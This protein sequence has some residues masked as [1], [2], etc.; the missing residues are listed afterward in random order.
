MILATIVVPA[1]DAEGLIGGCLAALERQ[2]VPRDRYEVVV[3]DDGSADG[4]A[5][6]ARSF[7]GVR[8]LRQTGRGPAAARTRGARAARGEIVVFTD[9]DCEPTEG[10]LAALLAPFA[11]PEVVGTKG[12]Y[13]T[14]QRALT[15]RFTQLEYEDKY[16]RMRRFERIDFID[17]YAAAFRRQV[18]LEAGGYDESFPVPSAEDVDLSYRMAAAGHLL[19]FAPAAAV[20]HR[21]PERPGVYLRRKYRYARWR[22]KAVART[23]SKAVSDSHSPLANK[24]QVVLMVPLAALLALRAAGAPARRP[25]VGAVAAHAALSLPFVVK[26]ARRDPSVAA[27][28]PLMLLAR[29]AFQ[30]A[31]IAAGALAGLRGLLRKRRRA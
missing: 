28:A 3:V 25:L 18:F 16:D 9:A 15:A 11:D 6:V 10:W 26:A 4:T 19:R 12:T 20:Y 29:S 5:E 21:H 13:L 14:R 2:T 23:P 30:A 31:G 8:L 1:R 24:A 7:A 22:V 27:V 17:T